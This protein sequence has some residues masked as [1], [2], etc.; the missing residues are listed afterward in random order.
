[1]PNNKEFNEWLL[2]GM[3]ERGWSQS[4]LAATAD[5][6]RAAVSDILSGRRKPGVRVITAITRAFRVPKEQGLRAAGILSPI[7]KRSEIADQLLMEF[8]GLPEEEKDNI[9]EY[10]RMRRRVADKKRKK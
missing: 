10:I 7:P 4:D 5:I 6:S 2:K 3:E 9:L 1:M 8:E